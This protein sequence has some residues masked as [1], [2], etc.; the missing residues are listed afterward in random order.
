MTDGPTGTEEHH[1]TRGPAVKAAAVLAGFLCVCLIIL[2]SEYW[3]G[4]YSSLLDSPELEQLYK[5]MEQNPDN[6]E[7]KE[8]IRR[9]DLKLREQF[10]RRQTLLNRGRYIAA[11][12]AVLLLVCIRYILSLKPPVQKRQKKGTQ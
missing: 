2:V 10:F 1:R 3:Q 6:E 12:C 9:K 11:A 7:L 5:K 4:R 8:R